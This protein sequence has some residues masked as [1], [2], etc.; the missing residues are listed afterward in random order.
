M[1]LIKLKMLFDVSL[2]LTPTESS[3]TVT[4]LDFFLSDGL[5]LFVPFPS[6]T[7]LTLL[8]SRSNPRW[9]EV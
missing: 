3:L 6:Y 5:S 7:S 8:A 2:W 9:P 4:V 1:S